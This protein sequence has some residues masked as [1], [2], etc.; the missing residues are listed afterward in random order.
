[1]H[2][3][4]SNENSSTKPNF[5]PRQKWWGP[6][7]FGRHGPFRTPWI[8]TKMVV[9]SIS[10][11]HDFV[12]V[13]HLLFYECQNLFASPTF[14]IFSTLSVSI[15]DILFGKNVRRLNL[16]Q[17]W[18]KLLF[19][20]TNL[21]KF[22]V[23]SRLT[24]PGLQ[25]QAPVLRQVTDASTTYPLLLTNSLFLRDERTHSA[26]LAVGTWHISVTHNFRMTNFQN[27]IIEWQTWQTRQTW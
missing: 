9:M 27:D 24:V 12:F 20:C 11:E 4:G 8:C 19:I 14:L 6:S 21:N 2:I 23:R 13:W 25:Q 1:M 17:R 26:S 3:F 22:F 15:I 16:F 7:P 10:Q 5:S 18:K